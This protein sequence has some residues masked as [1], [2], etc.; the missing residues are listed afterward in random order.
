MFAIVDLETT[1]GDPAHDRIM[2][3]AVVLHNGKR[4][5]EEYTTLVNPGISISPFITAL[6]GISSEMVADAPSFAD[7]HDHILKITADK[8]FVAHNARFDYGILRNEFKRLGKVFQRKQLCT[9]KTSRKVLPGLS[10]YSLGR[11]CGD[12]GIPVAS[13]HR[14]FGD[15]EATAQLFEYL[16]FNDRKELIKKILNEGL[17]EALLPDNISRKDL[18]RLP[19]DTGVY[20]FYD[21][22]GNVIYIGKSTNIRKRVLSHFSGDLK[23]RKY[24]E[25]KNNID[26]ISFDI[27]GNELLALILESYQ[28]KRFMP[29]YNNAQKRKKYRFG[30]Y[31]YTDEDE[32]LRIRLKT[33]NGESEPLKKFTT[34]RTAES[35]LLQLV[36][37]YNL[38]PLMCDGL[39][40]EG[41]FFA[42]KS[43]HNKS[44]K[45]IVEE[46]NYVHPD[47]IWI[48]EGRYF[49]EQSVILVE[50]NEFQGF[51]YLDNNFPPSNIEEIKDLI[52]PYPENPDVRQIINT[53][54][55]KKKKG[56]IK[57]LQQINSAEN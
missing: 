2:E 49:N 14:A 22:K 9:V 11:L 51:G 26:D 4:V 17:E 47:F 12:L 39:H 38:N 19:E 20:Y 3:I 54:I 48:G 44:I 35:Y 52:S 7:I 23:A 37:K 29:V 25:M 30:L 50:N 10:S 31:H 33:I 8:I 15:A 43:E 18:D 24:A 46:Q 34:R 13:R 5:I 45:R 36:Y 55:R 32:N 21:K 42:S 53:W 57:L 28:I 1:G 27:T 16:L 6:T 40:I 56:S 41:A